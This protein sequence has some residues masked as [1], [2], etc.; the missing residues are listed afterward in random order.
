MNTRVK[1]ALK[2]FPLLTLG[3]VLVALGVYFFK[4]P[5]N[6]STGGV[7]GIAILLSAVFP[8]VSSS[9]FASILNILFLILGFLVLN[10][11]F[12]VRTIYCSLLFSALLSGLEWL[13]PMSAP[14]TDQPLLELLFAVIL[15]AL[16][17]GILFN[18]QGSTGGTDIL[19]MILK[20]FTNIDIGRALL[21]V[22]VIVAGSTLF[23]INIQTGLFSLLGLLLKSVLVDTVI[24]SIN[25][26]KSVILV[27]SKPDEVSTFI[28]NNLHRSATIW[29]AKGAYS[30]ETK[31]VVMSAL[32]RSQAVILRRWLK[33]LDPHAF[34]MITNSS[35]IFG[36]GFLR[37]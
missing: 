23:L 27:T 34:I 15:P 10:K 36:K 20:K 32:S 18:M 33:E 4:F 11:G 29:E 9:T 25:R 16:G 8:A 14:F 12:G 22:D 7:T 13:C 26:K 30:H 21:Y 17:S 6:F 37:A 24:E 28:T 1:T 31:W 35:E 3:T 5:N 19:A 2:E